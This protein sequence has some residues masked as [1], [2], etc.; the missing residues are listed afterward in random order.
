[1]RQQAILTLR[2]SILYERFA[3]LA[4]SY[5][6]NGMKKFAG[7]FCRACACFHPA[8]E[9]ALVRRAEERI[10][11][12]P[13]ITFIAKLTPTDVTREKVEDVIA[14]FCKLYPEELPPDGGTFKSYLD[15]VERLTDRR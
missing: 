15:K 12:Q 7:R 10:S 13:S 3:D 4:L 9:D 14:L 2:C 6:Q 5:L 8:E 11:G 1:V